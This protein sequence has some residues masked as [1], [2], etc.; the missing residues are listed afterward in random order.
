[1]LNDSNYRYGFNGQER[2][3][4]LMGGTPGG[5]GVN[6][7]AKFWEYNSTLGR[8]MNLDPKP[9][10]SLSDY[11]VFNNNQTAQSDPLGDTSYRFSGV[12]GY[13]LG[14]ADPGQLGQKGVIENKG[15]N[16]YF[17]FADPVEDPY[18][19]RTQG[20]KNINKIN[21]VDDKL[22]EIDIKRSGAA[23]G[24]VPSS[25][26]VITGSYFLAKHSNA[27]TNDGK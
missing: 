8:R 3:D 25:A 11:S 17:S 14:M 9:S 4:L 27:G 23:A 22:I 1:M 10:P 16:Q 13:Y 5:V 26:S 24:Y 6:Y 20:L 18:N 12:T 19:I 2:D 21:V 15:I 7:G